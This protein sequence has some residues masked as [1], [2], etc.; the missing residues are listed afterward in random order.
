MSTVSPT[1]QRFR[2]TYAR[3]HALRYVSHLDMHLVW[4]RTFRRSRLPLAY[5]KGFSPHPRLHLA[6][7]LPLGILSRCEVLDAWF[8]A[9][10][11]NPLLEADDV[12]A[13]TQAAAPPGL[14]LSGALEVA[15]NDPPLQTQVS[16]AEY[17]AVPL[18]LLDPA[19]LQQCA[20]NLLNA[21]ELPR[22]K[23]DKP[24]DLRPLV[25]SLT[26]IAPE[27][28]TSLGFIMRLSAREGATGRP[29]EVLATLGFDPADFRIERTQLIFKSN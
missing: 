24:Y 26:V 29:E 2:L 25:E 1:L 6:A 17:L 13:M 28:P 8:D 15:L 20:A 3:G 5:S 4:E 10:P 27:S 12:L 23:R 21:V 22:M 16:A 19:R 14:E 9:G 7:A 11:N 18:D